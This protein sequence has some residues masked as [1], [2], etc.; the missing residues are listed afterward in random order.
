MTDVQDS[1]FT[2][3]ISFDFFNGLSMSFL[4]LMTGSGGDGECQNAS[5]TD[6]LTGEGRGT[7]RTN[8]EV[9]LRESTIRTSYTYIYSLLFKGFWK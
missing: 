2:K 8:V 4:Y 6:T 7:C 9:T 1:I 5:V 3:K